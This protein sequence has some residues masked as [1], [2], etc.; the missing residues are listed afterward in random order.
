MAD[1]ATENAAA[2]LVLL[3]SLGERGL[4]AERSLLVVVDRSKA[5]PKAV[6]EVFGGGALAHRCQMHKKRNMFDHLPKGCA[7]KSRLRSPKHTIA[8]ILNGHGAF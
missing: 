5:L 1:G 2:C 7:G 8:A 4:R 3:A 6:R